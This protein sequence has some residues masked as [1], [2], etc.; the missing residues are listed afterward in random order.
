MNNLAMKMKKS[1]QQGSTLIEV[2]VSIVVL[3]IGLLGTAG[4]MVNSM[5]SLA[6]QGNNVAASSFA[7]ELAERMM[8]NR[9]QALRPA[10]TNPYL[11]DTTT[12]GWPSS[13]IDCEANFCTDIQRAAWDTSDWS[14]RIRDAATPGSIPGA[15]VKVCYDSLTASGGAA[16]Q[17]VCTPGANPA[18][19]VK[20]AWASR[21]AAGNVENTSAG[22]P[23]PRAVY[24][25]TAGT[26]G[27]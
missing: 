17:W 9:Q 25:V 15:K 20:I 14:F 10:A 16:N 5:R 4:L 24:I 11:F 6:E 13:T 23:T 3:S 1:A 19:V 18:L 26:A 27:I 7:R 2:L 8:A 12:T 22:P 21:D